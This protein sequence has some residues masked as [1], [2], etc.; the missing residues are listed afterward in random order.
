MCG[1]GGEINLWWGNGNLVGG[2]LGEGGIFLGGR[3][4]QILGCFGEISLIPKYG[5]PCYYDFSVKNPR[6]WLFLSRDSA[7]QRIM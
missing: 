3:N 1:G 6:Y 5:K 2:Q 7:D 4:E